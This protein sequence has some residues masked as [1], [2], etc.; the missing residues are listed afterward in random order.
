MLGRNAMAWLET[1]GPVLGLLPG[2]TYEFDAV[3]LE[4]RR[5]GRHLQ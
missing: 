1:G 5:P 2:A 3:T 4:A